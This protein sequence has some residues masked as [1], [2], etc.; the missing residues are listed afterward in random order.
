MPTESDLHMSDTDSA[1]LIP[2]PIVGSCRAGFK[3]GKV[4]DGI[5]GPGRRGS[6]CRNMYLSRLRLC[7]IGIESML[8]SDQ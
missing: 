8:R 6:A 4:A 3:A 2:M 1:I 7:Y 5:H